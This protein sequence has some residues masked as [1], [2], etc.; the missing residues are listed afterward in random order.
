[1]LHVNKGEKCLPQPE[2][3]D[4]DTECIPMESWQIQQYPTCNNIHEYD[5][6][7]SIRRSKHNS[8]LPDDETPKE[9]KDF[10]YILDGLGSG[11]YRNTW[12]LTTA[13][14]SVALKT[15]R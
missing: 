3:V 13:S 7:R 5:M 4:R 2:K 14:E 12:L 10:D 15:L 6:G 9:K 1:M 11:W 8:E